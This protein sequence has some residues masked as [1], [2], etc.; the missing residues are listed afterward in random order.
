MN[1]PV[2]YGILTV[3]ALVGGWAIVRGAREDYADKSPSPRPGDYPRHFGEELGT[4]LLVNAA[5]G[6]SMLLTA[7]TLTIG[8]GERRLPTEAELASA[9]SF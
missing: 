9:F 5:M 8:I 6:A 1:R 4:T 7:K 3:A 2:A